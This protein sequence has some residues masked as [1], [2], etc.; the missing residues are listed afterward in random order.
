MA[1]APAKKN[2]T[3]EPPVVRP[4]QS[5]QLT[6]EINDT[7]VDMTWVGTPPKEATAYLSVRALM[8][9]GAAKEFLTICA[10]DETTAGLVGEM[11]EQYFVALEL[12]SRYNKRLKEIGQAFTHPKA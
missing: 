7:V 12:E 8:Q 11:P 3:P 4:P 9:D 5:L 1:K 10:A 2:T 6:V